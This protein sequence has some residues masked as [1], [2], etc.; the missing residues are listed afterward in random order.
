MSWRGMGRRS[1]H[2]GRV[3]PRTLSPRPR[4]H[5]Y[6]ADYP[7]NKISLTKSLLLRADPGEAFGGAA[8]GIASVCKSNMWTEHTPTTAD[9]DR[10]VWPRLC[11]LAEVGWTPKEL[12]NVS[13]FNA[14][15]ESQVQRLNQLGVKIQLPAKQK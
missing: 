11:A 1:W 8:S 13:D 9:V 12:R 2:G 6:L 10:M 5:C 15:M 3:G 7:A 14:R 4:P